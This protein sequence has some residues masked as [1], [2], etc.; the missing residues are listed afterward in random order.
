MNGNRYQSPLRQVGRS[1][2]IGLVAAAW[3][4]LTEALPAAAGDVFYS[5]VDRHGT[6][7]FT[8]V[9]TDPR[10]K[11]IV[12]RSPYFRHRL[13]PAQLEQAIS[14]HAQRH[15]LEPAL[16][17]AV[18]KAESDFDPYA[19]SRAGA[20]GLMQLMP[21]TA[22]RYGVDPYDPEENI[23]GGA[24]YLSD[25]IDMFGADIPLAVA[26]YNAGENNVIKYGNRIPP[27]QETQDYVSRVMSYY[28][29]FN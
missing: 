9:P 13:S 17:R 8:N 4:L 5:Y 26:A 10:F 25:L 18:I 1:A 27:F 3:L 6:I 16:L 2:A 24:R 22:A 15:R 7:H 12:Q 11:R 21:A 28:N 14:H 20:V 19:V 23:L 29:R